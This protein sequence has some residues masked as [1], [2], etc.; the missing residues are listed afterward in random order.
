M[1]RWEETVAWAESNGCPEIVGE[2]PDSDFYFVDEPTTYRIGPL[3]GP[4]YRSWDFDSKPRPSSE[5][6]CRCLVALT[7]GWSEIVGEDLA[8]VTRPLAFS[9]RK[10]AA[11]LSTL[12]P[13]PAHLGGSGS[14]SPAWNPN[15]EP[16][17]NF[18]QQ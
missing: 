16:S 2:I 5:E 9:G 13:T 14:V 15:E 8:R 12:M 11:F 6:I 7:N 4:M 17:P 3:G 1:Q 10:H 18:G